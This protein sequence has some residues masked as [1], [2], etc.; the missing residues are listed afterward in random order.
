MLQRGLR[1][2]LL[3]GEGKILQDHDRLRAGIHELVLELARRVKR[4]DVDHHAAGAQ[5]AGERDR[6]LR[7]VRHHERDACARCEPAGLQPGAEG[8]RLAVDLGEADALV[9]E[10]V[11][12]APGVSPESIFDQVHQRAVLRD[13]DVG[14]DARR[15]V[16]QPESVHRFPLLA[17]CGRTGMGT[18]QTSM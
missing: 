10:R 15:I 12:I 3:Q 2:H 14:G 9:H 17:Q 7:Q 6:V 11:G 1:D 18:L 16:L 4:V 5:H 13:V 8:C